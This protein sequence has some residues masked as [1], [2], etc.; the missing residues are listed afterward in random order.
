MIEHPGEHGFIWFLGIV[1]SID[2]P[3][4][5]G[6]VKIR[7]INEHENIVDSEDIPWAIVL[8]STTSAAYLG[9]GAAPVGIQ[10]PSF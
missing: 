10:G 5:L 4:Q 1:D 7:V 6:R 9:L 8:G 3:L 2:D